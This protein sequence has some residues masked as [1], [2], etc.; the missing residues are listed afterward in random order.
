MSRGYGQVQRALL[1]VLTADQT[2]RLETI[3]LARRVSSRMS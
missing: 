1:A 3:E 2:S